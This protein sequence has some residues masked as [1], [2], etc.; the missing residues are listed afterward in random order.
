MADETRD[1]VE[2]HDRTI[3]SVPDKTWRI[4]YGAPG[5]DTL[6]MTIQDFYDNISVSVLYDWKYLSKTNVT[7][8]TPTEDY[9]PAT[10]KYV[11]E[12]IPVIPSSDYLTKGIVAIGDISADENINVSFESAISTDKYLVVGNIIS[13]GASWPNDND[14]VVTI[15]NRTTLGFELLL[16]ETYSVAQDITFEY[17]ILKF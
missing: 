4:A 7:S 1:Y 11:D 12:R 16:R 8:Y 2:L 9:H 3:D 5:E 6:N 15:K 10:K 14:V 17:K 13:N